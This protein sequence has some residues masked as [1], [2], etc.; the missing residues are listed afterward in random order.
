MIIDYKKVAETNTEYFKKYYTFD[1][2]HHFAQQTGQHYK[3]LTYIT[4]LFDNITILDIGTYDGASC[5]A[6]A[7]N[8]NNKVLTYDIPNIHYPNLTDLPFL[9]DYPNVTRKIMDIN[10]EDSEIIKSAKVILLDIVHDGIAEKQFSDKLEAIG[11][12][13]YVFC[14]DVFSLHHPK[15]T[16]WFAGLKIEKYNLTE[17]GGHNGTG[18]LNYYNDNSVIIKKF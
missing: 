8:K 16:E 9:S 14:D 2:T 11:Y 15:C 5:L 6:L 4:S 12:T 10:T 18:L 17:T 1:N 13:G 3:L 7:Q